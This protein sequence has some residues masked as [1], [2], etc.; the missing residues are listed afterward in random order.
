MHPH[1]PIHLHHHLHI[2]RHPIPTIKSPVLVRLARNL[3]ELI[4]LFFEIRASEFREALVGVVA[5]FVDDVG[6][7]EGFLVGEEL[8]AEVPEVRGGEAEDRRGGFVAEGAAGVL[9]AC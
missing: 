4:D 2:P 6:V 1:Q 5:G 9:Y 3:Q 7:E 8:G